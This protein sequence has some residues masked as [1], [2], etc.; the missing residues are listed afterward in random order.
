MGDLLPSLEKARLVPGAASPL[1]PAS[2][3]PTLDLAI[4]YDA[5]QVQNGTLLRV[6][7]VKT[8]PTVH[9][10]A[11]VRLPP[12]PP[13]LTSSPRRHHTRSCW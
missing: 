10:E 13:Q 12:C 5:K 7:E 8:A 6:S 2:W 9:F 4:S 1:I 3:T 11:E